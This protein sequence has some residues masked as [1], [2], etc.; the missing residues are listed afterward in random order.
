M[1]RL[2]D[3]VA[4]ALGLLVLMP[5][6]AACAVL[7]RF[8]SP[9]PV[10]FRQERMGRGGRPFTLLKFR[11]MVAGAPR[12]GP[13]VTSGRDARITRVGRFLRDTKLDELPQIFNVLAG[14][15]S[16]VGPRPEVR[17]YVEM[18]A[19]DYAHVLSVR[20]GITD[21]AAIEFRNEEDLLAGYDDA[22]RAYVDLV[23]PRKIEL[24]RKY[25]ASQGML[26]DL[27]IIFRTLARI[28]TG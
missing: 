4:S 12:L 9:G 20:P 23:L 22:E 17:R 28:A 21:Y 11:T 2:F 8:D 10:L 19:E 25:I 3:V 1:K 6:L 14:Q 15:M 24:Y 13:A 26:T 18:F 16:I 7:V 27:V 5:V